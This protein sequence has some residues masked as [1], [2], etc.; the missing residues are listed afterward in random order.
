MNMDYSS[1]MVSL[2]L[3][4]VAFYLTIAWS[5]YWLSV[6]IYRV[7]FSPLAKFPGPKLAAATFW[8]EFYYDVYPNKF[9]YLWKIKE[10]HEQYGPIVRINPIHL[11]IHDHDF[12]DT[13]YAGGNHK[14]GR[15]SWYMH[16]GAKS[17][18]GGLVET[19]S[20]DLHKARRKPVEPF[21]SKRSVQALEQDIVAKVEKLIGR[22][23]SALR[24]SKNG[25]DKAAIVNLSDAMAGLTLDVISDYCFGEPTGALDM[26]N[27]GHAFAHALHEGVQIRPVGRHF[28]TLINTMMDMPMWLV[29]KM[30][31]RIAG[32]V[33]WMAGL[34]RM[35]DKIKAAKKS[36]EKCQTSRRTLFDEYLDKDLPPE[37]KET[38]VLQG[39]A[40]N[41]VGAGTETTARTLAVTSYYLLQNPK[42]LEK[43][44][45]E[46]RAVMPTRDSRP[47]LPKLETLPYLVSHTK[48]SVMFTA[49]SLLL[50]VTTECG[51]Q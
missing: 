5:L 21:F 47:S 30:N 36:G 13:I 46:L 3:G 16:S 26:E 32:F 11:H 43:L 22:L 7:Y 24:S 38:W 12:Y 40:A 51:D 14:R 48:C 45:G 6:F 20:H 2:G 15:C 1:A 4:T 8:Y 19:I 9:Q 23:S 17:T 41:F 28:P 49:R 31:P 35:I 39:A 33:D 50:M 27:Y 37:E 25:D 42:M 10:L 44:R 29:A 34:S 18:S